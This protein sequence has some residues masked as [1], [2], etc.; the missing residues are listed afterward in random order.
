MKQLIRTA[1]VLCIK[2]IQIQT[3]IG[4]EIR[5]VRKYLKMTRVQKQNWLIKQ[6]VCNNL[7]IVSNDLNK[8]LNESEI[9]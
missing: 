9:K 2:L 3:M 6:V 7:N 8:Q 4:L 5:L 1:S